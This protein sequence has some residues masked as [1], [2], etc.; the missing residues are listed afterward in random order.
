M[1]RW[2]LC[3]AVLAGCSADTPAP[4]QPLDC[5]PAQ[6]G[7]LLQRGGAY[8]RCVD[9]QLI[10]GVG[11]GPEGYP[12]G[13]G[14]KYA[15]RFALEIHPVLSEAGQRF[16]ED[17]GACLQQRMA[18]W[19]TSGSSCGEVWTQA[20]EDHPGCYLDSGFCALELGDTLI[21][22]AA[23]DPEDHQLPEQQAQ[24]EVI[25]AGCLDP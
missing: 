3:L 18:A 12:L 1:R 7:E 15:D 21:I 20:F 11:C 9:A 14:A 4:L 25:A 19:I 17:T 10:D 2:S 5:V 24:L 22:S 16:L 6:P 23:V 8:Y 13:Y